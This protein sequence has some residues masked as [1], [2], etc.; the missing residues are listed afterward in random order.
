MNFG[1]W[2]WAS[3]LKDASLPVPPLGLFL[4]IQRK[5]KNCSHVLGGPDDIQTAL[6]PLE[7][8]EKIE[9]KFFDHF[10]TS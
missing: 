3:Y 1:F 6:K 4:V 10:K 9:I 5:L 2:I 8:W 7:K